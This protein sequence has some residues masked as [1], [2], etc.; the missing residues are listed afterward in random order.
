MAAVESREL[1]STVRSFAPPNCAEAREPH[2]EREQKAE[3]HLEEH[4]NN[5]PSSARQVRE[6]T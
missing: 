6:S 5:R 3:Q 1:V 2:D 4:A